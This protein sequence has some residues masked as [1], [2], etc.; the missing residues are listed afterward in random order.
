MS[1]LGSRYVALVCF[2]D[3]EC[4]ILLAKREFNLDWYLLTFKG[5]FNRNILYAFEYY[6]LLF[7]LMYVDHRRQSEWQQYR[8]LEGC[9]EMISGFWIWEEAGVNPM[10]GLFT[11][12]QRIRL[13]DAPSV[14]NMENGNSILKMNPGT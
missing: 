5:K 8:N 9:N 2:Y 4:R 3:E 12:F 1:L 6:F 10:V 13:P 11:H 7:D 14:I